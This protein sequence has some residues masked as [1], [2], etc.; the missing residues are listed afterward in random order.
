MKTRNILITIIALITVTLL[1]TLVAQPGPPGNE[2]PLEKIRD[3]LELTEEQIDQMR[4]LKYEHRLAAIDLR[5][6]LGKEKLEMEQLMTADDFDRDAIYKQA[7][8]VAELEKQLNLMRIESKLDAME[9]LTAEQREEFEEL[10]SQ[11][12]GMRKFGKGG[13][14]RF[15]A[16][17]HGDKPMMPGR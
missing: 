8:K 1:G 17:P 4:E 2:P 12:L 10:R 3:E 16:C 14:N 7:E 15:G 5:A 13:S 11:R 9:I 6:E